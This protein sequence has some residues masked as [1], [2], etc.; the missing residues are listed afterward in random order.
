M[1]LDVV[2]IPVSD[3]DRAKEFCGGLGWRLDADV[4]T[5]DDLRLVQMTPPGS[6]CSVQFGMN[7]TSTAPGSLK[8]T[9]L[10]VSDIG[11][12]RDERAK[13]GVEITEVFH[14]D[15]GFACRFGGAAAPGRVDGRGPD[16]GTYS[17]FASF[18]D[19][20]GNSWLLQEVTTRLLGR[21][22]PAA[23][24]FEVAQPSSLPRSRFG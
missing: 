15:T 18:S 5:G 4:A 2:V 20:D 17:S 24:A 6:A 12:V 3:V 1:K 10:I 13:S 19:P 9:Y 16:D 11:T 21:I 7:L 14:C 8:S 22:D 23:T